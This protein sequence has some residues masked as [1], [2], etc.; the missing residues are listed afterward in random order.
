MKVRVNTRSSAYVVLLSSSFRVQFGGG[1]H[2]VRCHA[3]YIRESRTRQV[4]SDH[5]CCGMLYTFETCCEQSCAYLGHTCYMFAHV[6][7]LT[8]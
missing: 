5:V 7:F 3:E 6:G 4:R 2:C 1:C 8:C